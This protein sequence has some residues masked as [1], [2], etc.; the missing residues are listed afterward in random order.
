MPATTVENRLRE[1][2]TDGMINFQ[3]LGSEGAP[4]TVINPNATGPLPTRGY[5]KELTLVDEIINSKLPGEQITM[6][7]VYTELIDNHGLVDSKLLYASVIKRLSVLRTRGAIAG[8]ERAKSSEIR[9]VS[10]ADDKQV[11]VLDLVSVVRDMH[12]PTPEFIK[13]GK[14]KLYEVLRD[15]QTV[16]TLLEKAAAN[17]PQ[18]G[19]LPKERRITLVVQALDELRGPADPQDIQA[20]IGNVKITEASSQKLLRVMEKDGRV[21]RHDRV[22]RQ[23]TKW[24]LV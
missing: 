3:I 19:T 14:E 23:L 12:D 21:K 4:R 2:A 1:M 17:S 10:I 5:V 24:A 15:K 20:H 11:A 7:K 18:K 8:D 13:S 9:M 22:G 16:R 6:K